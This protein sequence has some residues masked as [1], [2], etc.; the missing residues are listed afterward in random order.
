M[1]RL[2]LGGQDLFKSVCA[3]PAHAQNKQLGRTAAHVMTQCIV[4]CRFV[5]CRATCRDHAVPVPCCTASCLSCRFVHAASCR[6]FRFVQCRATCRDHA[7]LVPVVPFRSCRVVPFVPFCAVPCGASAVRRVVSCC[8]VSCH[9]S[10]AGAV[11]VAVAVPC[12]VVLCHS[13][14]AVWAAE[15]CPRGVSWHVVWCRVVSCCAARHVASRVSPMCIVSC[16][17]GVVSCRVVSCRT[18][19]CRAVLCCVVAFAVLCRAVSCD[20]VS[21]AVSCW[22]RV[23]S[24]RGRRRRRRRAMSCRAVSFVSCRVGRSARRVVPRFVLCR[25]V[26]C[27]LRRRCRRR[28]RRAMSCRVVSF[29]SCRVGCRGVSTRR[30]VACRV[31]SCCI[32][33]CRTACRLTSIAD[34]YRVVSCRCRVVSCRVVPYR[35]VPCRAVLCRGIRCAVSCRVV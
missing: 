26:P 11:A 13:C 10:C 24:C 16:H 6:S 14:R 5:Q 21:V 30:V 31:V 1:A 17:V 32:L 28:R 2:I 12:R 34:V 18:V 23:V 22:W 19:P 29:V 35:T 9:V 15:V 25:V 4:S 33:L 27:I 3:R 20:G 8:A 7:V